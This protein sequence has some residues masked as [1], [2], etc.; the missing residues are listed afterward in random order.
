MYHIIIVGT[1]PWRENASKYG[2]TLKSNLINEK[3]CIKKAHKRIP[4]S[5]HCEG[6]RSVTFLFI[7]VNHDVG[8]ES[9]ES[10]PISLGY[11][12]ASLNA[13]GWDGVILDDLR[14]RT[15]A[16]TSLNRWL[17]RIQPK[18][19]GFTAF[20]STMERI[21]FLAHAVKSQHPQILIVLGGPQVVAMPSEALNDLD[22]I[23]ILVRGEAELIMPQLA[24]AL[25]THAALST[26]PGITFRNNGT[27]MDT[28]RGAPPP[29]DLD[30]Y[31][32]PYLSGI[33]NLEGKKTAI[34]L[35]SRGCSHVCRF[36][37]TPRICRGVVRFHSVERVCEEMEYL[38]EEGIERFWFADPNFTESR[39]RTVRLLEEKIRRRIHTPFWFQ[40]RADL[41]DS[42]L[43]RLLRRAGA[44]TVAFGLE[45]GSPAVL[46]KTGKAIE[47]EHLAKHIR[48]AQDLGMEAELFSIFGLPEETVEDARQTLFFVRSLGIPIQSNSG[49]QQMQLY[50]GSVYE[51]MPE[52]Y[53]I[54]PFPEYRPR[55]LSVGDRFETSAM[56]AADIRK[57]RNMW[58][59]A[60]EQ[61]EHD[62][63]Y[64]QRVFEVL[65]FL[66]ENRADLETERAFYAFG[67]LTAAAIEEWDI[68]KEFLKGF[69]LI[70]G[71]DPA[72]VAE[73][74]RSLGFFQETNEPAGP[75]DRVIFDAR[76]WMDGVPFMGISGKYW[77]VLLGRGLL[78]PEFEQGLVGAQPGQETRFRFTFPHDYMEQDLQGRE[79]EVVVKIHTVLK[80]VLVSSLAEVYDL[81]L[82]NRYPF[83]DL[84]LLQ[85]NNDILYYLALRDTNPDN[86]VK[87]PRHFLMFVHKLAKLGKR[88]QVR[89]LA[90]RVA[91]RPTALGAIAD[92]LMAADKCSWAI[93]YYDRLSQ[94][95]PGTVI[96]KARCLLRIGETQEA[97]ATLD[98]LDRSAHSA[99]LEF[100]ETLLEC[101][102]VA[103]PQSDC[104]PLLERQ[105]L[106]LRVRAAMKREATRGGRFGM[107]PVVHSAG[108]NFSERRTP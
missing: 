10:I 34:L 51:S 55:Y 13:A 32:S 59:L 12:L 44:D 2:A 76:S 98:T 25:H 103:Q 88:D 108:M 84:D 6:R 31:P 16:L 106:D 41:V 99:D 11:I 91:D 9:S 94:L 107:P 102:K 60:N 45:S 56:T 73:L 97:L 23:D 89:K 69:D 90:A 80:T 81:S 87:Q 58:A 8:Y 54:V 104:I 57:V 30:V 38:Q 79:V 43:L 53:G 93:E 86:L 64:K 92:T 68:M 39:D 1:E 71:H 15:L 14:D 78:L 7:N 85:E 49:S 18:V 70:V 67:A 29:G 5:K 28:G 63:Y 50:F 75:T 74:V 22:D 3:T 77:D 20:Q 42:E 37:I 19:I 40:T 47:L 46:A 17:H 105:V 27:V 36:C 95:L 26:V 33:L 4:T 65:D 72:S 35:S 61:M 100:Q 24:E 21:R 52:R 96:K 48:T 101:L 83:T 82:S 62:V 66:L